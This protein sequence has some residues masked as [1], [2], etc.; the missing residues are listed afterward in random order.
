V[1]ED[2]WAAWATIDPED[3]THLKIQSVADLLADRLPT[4]VEAVARADDAEAPALTALMS[5]GGG[6]IHDYVRRLEEVGLIPGGLSSG[7]A[8]GTAPHEVSPPHAVWAAAQRRVESMLRTHVAS[9]GDGQTVEQ[10][11]IAFGRT[12]FADALRAAAS[13]WAWC[14]NTGADAEAG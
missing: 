13:A 1:S 10:A 12:D 2:W 9:M 8:A 5:P 4:E 14:R 11:F 6:R 7:R 3:P